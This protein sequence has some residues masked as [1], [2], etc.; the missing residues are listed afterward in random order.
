[1]RAR[2]CRKIFLVPKAVT[3]EKICR[4]VLHLWSSIHQRQ[5]YLST[6]CQTLHIL[7]NKQPRKQK[8]DASYRTTAAEGVRSRVLKY[9]A[10]PEPIYVKLLPIFVAVRGLAPPEPCL[11]STRLLCTRPYYKSDIR[12]SCI[13]VNCL[14]FSCLLHNLL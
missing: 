9:I 3:M 2:R 8:L 11:T 7:Q 14:T 6:W 13:I 12:V 4:D 5:L 1:M 10:H